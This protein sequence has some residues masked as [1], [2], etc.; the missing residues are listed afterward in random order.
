MVMFAWGRAGRVP[1]NTWCRILSLPKKLN[2]ELGPQPAVLI[3]QCPTTSDTLIE[4]LNRQRVSRAEAQA[5][6]LCI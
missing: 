3:F 6:A 1:S 5:S 4:K 2:R